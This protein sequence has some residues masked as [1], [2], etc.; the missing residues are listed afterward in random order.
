MHIN[1]CNLNLTANQSLHLSYYL[2][3]MMSYI[4]CKAGIHA[5]ILTY[6]VPYI[7]IVIRGEVI[8]GGI[9]ND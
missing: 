2:V 8:S 5:Y 7:H 4:I 9:E 6:I 3:I 1:D